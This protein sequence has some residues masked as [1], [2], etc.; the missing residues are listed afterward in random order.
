[1]RRASLSTAATEQWFNLY[2]RCSNCPGSSGYV[3]LSFF[4]LLVFSAMVALASLHAIQRERYGLL[5]TL[6]FLVAFVGVAMIF[7]SESR[8]LIMALWQGSPGAGGVSWLLIIGLL[9]A[10]VGIITE[11]FQSHF[12]RQDPG[13]Q[14]DATDRG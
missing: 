9:V 6:V 14:E 7:V 5:G 8:S 1:M 13:G 12:V 2:D 10:T 3:V 11:P 4:V